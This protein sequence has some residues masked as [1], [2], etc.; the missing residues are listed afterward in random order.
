LAR[1]R[2]Q[3]PALRRGALQVLQAE[4]DTLVFVRLLDDERIL[5]AIQREGGTQLTVQANPLI[6]CPRWQRLAGSGEIENQG[7]DV[8]LRLSEPGI[9]LFRGFTR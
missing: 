2:Q 1:L 7:A 4:G 9:T 6:A 5:V 8:A 3:S